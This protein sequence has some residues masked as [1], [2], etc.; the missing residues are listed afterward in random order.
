MVTT[1]AGGSAELDRHEGAQA[2]M[3][4]KDV[5]PAARTNRMELGTGRLMACSECA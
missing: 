5:A 4:R 1:V 3:Y 2:K